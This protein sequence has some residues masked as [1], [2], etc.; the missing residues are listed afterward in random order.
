[1]LEC[2]TELAAL[3]ER[4]RLAN[5]ALSKDEGNEVAAKE[6]SDVFAKLQEIDADRAESQAATILSGAGCSDC[7]LFY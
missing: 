1:M 4:E 5:E 3:R 7:T 6:L 2:H